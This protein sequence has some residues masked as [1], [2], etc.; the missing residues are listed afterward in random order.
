M[1]VEI[2]SGKNKGKFRQVPRELHELRAVRKKLGLKAS[3]GYFHL[4]RQV[5]VPYAMKDTEYTLRLWETLWPTF[6]RKAAQ[7]PALQRL[8]HDECEL[9]LA[10]LDMEARGLGVDVEYLDATVA[11]YSV[12]VMEKLTE[13]VELSGNKDL[14]PGSPKQI[15]EAFAKMGED[16]DGTAVAALQGV[17]H[18]SKNA[19]A[20]EFAQAILDFRSDAKV[21][22]TYLKA[23]QSE[24]RE[25]IWHPNF[26]PVLPKTG[27]MSSGTAS[28]K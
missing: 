16:V 17:V 12:R 28:N 21:Y 20:R 24:Q 15:H 3:D 18:G 6:E 23:L 4:P 10:L 7:D 2:K 26:N 13:A 25:G 14:N 9:T 1:S 27:R 8:Y 5:I 22:V 11:E 19:K